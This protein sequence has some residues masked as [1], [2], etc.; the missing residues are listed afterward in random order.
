MSDPVLVVADTTPLNYLILIGQ[1]H[2]LGTLFDK[3]LIPE[4]VLEE[5]KHPKAPEAVTIWLQA[6]PAWLEV[7]RVRAL[8]HTI[9]LG[10]GEVEAISLALEKRLGIVLIDERKG[11]STA[12]SR[13][14]LAVGTLNLIDLA[15]EK[16]LLK[17][18]D[19]LN[20]L[21]ITTFRA[22]R[23]LVEQLEAKF[24]SRRA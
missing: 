1:A 17:G 9:Q 13:G 14:L 16:G 10:K 21:R 18:I 11:R 7:A 15:D 6:L 12:Q 2:I 4:G 8:D 23:R 19:A 20:K 5:L 24:I 22:D 3:V